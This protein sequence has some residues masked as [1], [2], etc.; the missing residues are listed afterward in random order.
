MAKRAAK[1]ESITP[2]EEK[3]VALLAGLPP[4]ASAACGAAVPLAA[5]AA[6]TAFDRHITAISPLQNGMIAGLLFAAM[7][8]R[9]ALMPERRAARPGVAAWIAGTA[10]GI[11]VL[12]SFGA[13]VAAESP[14]PTPHQL[15]FRLVG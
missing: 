11:M 1:F 13:P 15:P 10:V 3:F 7:V 12:A 14:S 4:A 9:Y 6:G 2:S 5:Y 8:F